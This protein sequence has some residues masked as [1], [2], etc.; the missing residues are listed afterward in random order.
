VQLTGAPFAAA[1]PQPRPAYRYLQLGLDL[2]PS[3]L[4]QR[5][6]GRVDRM[7][8]VGLIDEVRQL[9]RLGL[10]EGRTASRALGYQ[11]VLAHLRGECSLDQARAATIAATRRFVR[12]QRSWFRR[13][14]AVVWL[15]AA[16]TDCLHAAV[17]AYRTMG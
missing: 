7:W 1:L 10:A 13:D 17:T 16:S 3:V 4:D 14:G 11:Q 9:C 6:A 5:I 15:D 8:Q 12:R 2:D